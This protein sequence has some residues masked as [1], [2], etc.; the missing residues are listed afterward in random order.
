MKEIQGGRR[1]FRRIIGGLLAVGS[2]VLVI[3]EV[4]ET[5][6]ARRE[7]RIELSHRASAS[8]RWHG[9]RGAAL[10]PRAQLDFGIAR[11]SFVG[12]INAPRPA[13]GDKVLLGS[14]WRRVWGIVRRIRRVGLWWVWICGREH[15]RAGS[16]DGARGRWEGRVATRR[17]SRGAK[18]RRCRAH[19]GSGP[20]SDLALSIDRVDWQWDGTNGRRVGDAMGGRGGG[21][22][23][24][25]G[26]KWGCANRA[27]GQGRQRW[28]RRER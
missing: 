25:R 19:G 22:N 5:S 18:S 6:S 16:G 12:P 8:P 27:R 14:W 17:W 7:A 3:S 26:R 23:R 4:M 11:D 9:W 15:R 13:R 10:T 2:N 20:P 28:Q 24:C 21:M 1:T